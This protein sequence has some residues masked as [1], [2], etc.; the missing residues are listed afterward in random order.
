[1]STETITTN[2]AEL[3]Y[4]LLHA[5]GFN[6]EHA[7]KCY[8]FIQGPADD[9]TKPTTTGRLDGIYFVLNTPEGQ[10]AKE[11]RTQLTEEQK[12]QC[13]GIGVQRNGLSF[14]VALGEHDE[15]RLLPE[16]KKVKSRWLKHLERECDALH[17]TDSKGNTGRLIKDNP[18]LAEII[19]G[20]WHIPALAVLVEMCYLRDV[21]NQALAI[22]GGQPLRNTWYWSS[23]EGSQG[24][25]W[26][27]N[28]S[29]GYVTY[30]GKCNGD[31]V[32]AVAAF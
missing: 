4:T 13:V 24:N 2:P 5:T 29:S 23:T 10:V 25:A 3:R 11:Y 22:V 27:V 14:C 8:A 12:E 20:E 17:D 6:V 32:R 30:Y 9:E 1:M 15:V 16:G 19:G 21:I 18:T 7:R 28:F 26:G 31:A